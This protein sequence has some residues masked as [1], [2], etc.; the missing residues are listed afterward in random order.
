MVA[1]RDACGAVCAL[2]ARGGGQSKGDGSEPRCTRRRVVRCTRI[3]M[4]GA[5]GSDSHTRAPRTDARWRRLRHIAD[6]DADARYL[7]CVHVRG[8]Q[9]T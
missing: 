9:A 8:A 3:H 1:S 2:C 7:C 5:D 4:G 6:A